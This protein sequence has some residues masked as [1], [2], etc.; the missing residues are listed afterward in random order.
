MSAMKIRAPRHALLIIC[1]TGLAACGF[2]VLAFSGDSHG[3][4]EA[5]PAA[6]AQDA[7]PAAE[8]PAAA[9]ACTAWRFTWEVRPGDGETFDASVLRG[10]RLVVRGRLADL[11]FY[12]SHYVFGESR[13]LDPTI[14][15]TH[16][17]VIV[18]ELLLRSETDTPER[19]NAYERILIM[20]G[21]VMIVDP[22]ERELLSGTPVRTE[23]DATILESATPVASG[24][25]HP[26]LLDEDD[27]WS[28][29]PV[30]DESGHHMVNLQVTE[31]AVPTL[32]AYLDGRPSR[33]I[34]VLLDH[35]VIAVQDLEA[36]DLDTGAIAISARDG[37]QADALA[38]VVRS[39]AH[40][41]PLVPIDRVP[42]FTNA[43]I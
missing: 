11:G 36:S 30:V 24:P 28:A 23:R 37:D 43:C 7:S 35:E 26:I 3:G 32:E 41:V 38:I 16:N 40:Q 19:L 31:E 17:P 33:E 6:A 8:T 22:L 21:V 5:R 29:Y 39:E 34:A 15:T 18:V 9:P 1:M 12:Q 42:V 20:P 13:V 25:V 14:G 2:S 27:L 4:F 10:A